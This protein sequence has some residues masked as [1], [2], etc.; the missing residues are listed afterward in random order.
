MLAVTQHHIAHIAD[1]KAIHQDGSCRHDARQSDRIGTHLDHLAILGQDDVLT[2]HAHA[3]SQ[4][5]VLPQH[6]VFTVN[7]DKVMRLHQRV[8]QFQFFLEGVAG[9]V[10]I[11]HRVIY[12][13]SAAAV[14]LVDHAGD[15][16]LIAGNR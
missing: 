5:C 7:G 3:F 14:Q 8:H 1:T 12:H 15:I 4:L 9:S 6:P 10:N 11:R 16:D 13:L 2:G